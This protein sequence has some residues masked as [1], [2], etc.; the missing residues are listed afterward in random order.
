MATAPLDDSVEKLSQFCAVLQNTQNV[1]QTELENFERLS[2]Q[3]D[4]LEDDSE[5]RISGLADDLREGLEKVR[6][7]AEAAHESIDDLGEAAQAGEGVASEA[8]GDIEE[9]R[10]HLGQGLDGG[11]VDLAEH[12]GNL[13]AAGFE[14]LHITTEAAASGLEQAS[15]EVEEAF[16]EA[17][18]QTRS[19][20]QRLETSVDGVETA[21]SDVTEALGRSGQRLEQACSEAADGDA[22]NASEVGLESG[23]VSE[24]VEGAYSDLT[25]HVEEVVDGLAQNVA[26]EGQEAVETLGTQVQS[27]EEDFEAHV[28][29]ALHDWEGAAVELVPP[30]QEAEG[31][32]SELAAAVDDLCVV[33][34]VI[35]DV[36][37]LLDAVEGP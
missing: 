35:A 28:S 8:G 10:E 13:T 18:G 37:R 6:P 21:L 32:S 4:K 5:D 9:V 23:S 26:G 36:D 24:T 3:Y 12:F 25:S 22:E 11:A 15:Q 31:F 29:G 33:K 20:A 14:S 30:L 17:S 2:E 7:D 16:G 1:L 27:L 34:A 19:G